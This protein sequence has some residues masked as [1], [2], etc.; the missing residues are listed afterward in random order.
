MERVIQSSMF[1]SFYLFLSILFCNV[2]SALISDS[3]GYVWMLMLELY[4]NVRIYI[5]YGVSRARMTCCQ[6]SDFDDAEAD[7]L[8]IGNW[9]VEPLS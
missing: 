1:Y 2:D 3:N 7:I 8:E 4:S 9:R 6:W 5:I